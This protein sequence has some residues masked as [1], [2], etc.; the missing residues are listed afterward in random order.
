MCVFKA[1]V[2]QY[3]EMGG[4]TCWHVTIMKG[5]HG[6]RSTEVEQLAIII[7]NHWEKIISFGDVCCLF[8]LLIV[9]ANV[10]CFHFV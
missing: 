1:N 5:W 7:C 8:L 9:L 10:N 4:V 6:L 2:R 3:F